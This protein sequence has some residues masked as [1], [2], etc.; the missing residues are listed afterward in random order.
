[1]YFTAGKCMGT[2]VNSVHEKKAK[3]SNILH[4]L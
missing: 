1:M 2:K 4:I 3:M